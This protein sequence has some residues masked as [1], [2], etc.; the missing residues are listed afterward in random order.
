LKKT[1]LIRKEAKLDTVPH[2]IIYVVDKDST[3]K[4]TNERQQRIDMNAPCHML[5]I[6]L[7]IPSGTSETMRDDKIKIDLGSIDSNME[8]EDLE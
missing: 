4:R 3:V 2:L 5:G 8:R 7:D 1:R 6:C